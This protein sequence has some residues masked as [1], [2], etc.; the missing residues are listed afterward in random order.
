M[1]VDSKAILYMLCKEFDLS[2]DTRTERLKLQKVIYLLETYGM[3]AGYGFNW[4]RYGPYSQELVYDAHTVLCAEKAEYEERTSDWHFNSKTKEKFNRF[5]QLCGHMLDDVDKLELVA[6]VDFVYHTWYPDTD[7]KQFI[8]DFKKHKTRL[9]SGEPI[10][11]DMILKALGIS[12]KLRL[13]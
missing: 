10:T 9:H 5:R 3:Q 1:A 4:Y 8:T 6:S 12:Q 13:S 11:D 2:R 7:K